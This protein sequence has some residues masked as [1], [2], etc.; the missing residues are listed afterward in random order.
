MNKTHGENRYIAGIDIGSVSVNAA[1]LNYQKEIIKTWYR[2]FH[3]NPVTVA[4]EVLEEVFLSFPSSEIAISATGAGGKLISKSLG[5]F[6][7]NEVIAQAKA[8]GYLYPEAKTIIEMGGQDS[9]FILIEKTAKG[10]NVKIT[11]FATNTIC[12]AGTGSFLDQQANRLGVSIEEEFSE[13]ALKSEKPPRIAGRCSVFAKSDMIHLQQTGTPDYDIVAGLC[14]AVAR[15]FKSSIARGKKFIKPVAFQGGVASNM[16]MVRAFKDILGLKDDE[17]LVHEHHCV[18][19]AIGAAL[20][21]LEENPDD[22]LFTDVKDLDKINDNANSSGA[23][24]LPPLMIEKSG[25]LHNPQY[26]YPLDEKTAGGKL[27]VYL[28]IDVGSISTNVVAIDEEGEVAAR[29]YLMTAG[30][31]IEAVRTGLGEIGDEIGSRVEVA[32][33]GT[34]GSG[35]YL[36]GDLVGADII[37]N[38]ITA[39]AKA[40]VFIDPEVDTIFEIGG[41]DS[42][43]VSLSGGVVSDF[44][45]NKVCAAGTGS[46]LEEQAEKLKVN[47][48]DEFSS[49]ALKSQ[50]PVKL[51]ERCTV[52]IESDIVHHQQQGVS[53][54]DIVSGLSYSIVHNYL[55]RV[56][57]NRKIGNKI[58]FQGGVA[59]N[60]GVI[61]AFEKVLDKKITVPPHHDVTGAIGAAL[62]A[63]ENKPSK[64]AFKG[65]DLSKKKFNVK[66][67]ECK[68]CTNLCEIRMITMEGEKPLF[69]GSRCEKYDIDRK[70]KASGFTNYFNLRKEYLLNPISAKK[71]ARNKKKKR[72]GIP[73]ILYFY[74][75]FPMWKSFFEEL[76]CEIVLSSETNKLIIEKGTENVAAET[77]FPVKVAHGHVLDLLEKEI[78]FLFMPSIISLFR[79]NKSFAENHTCPYVQAA[80]YIINSSLGLDGKN[81]E[82]LQPI[83]HLQGNN[84]QAGKA[85]REMGKKL[86]ASMSEY[87]QAYRVAMDV[88]KR[89][90]NS[91]KKLGENFLSSLSEDEK[92]IVIVSRPYNGF[93]SSI[94][95]GLPEKLSGLGIRTIPMDF[96]PLKDADISLY[97]PNMY[98]KA[99]QRILSAAQYIRNHP[100]LFAVYITNFGCGPDSFLTHF[101][102]DI[103]KG[104]PFLQIEIDEHSADTGAVTRCEAF[105]DSL[106]NYR[107]EIQSSARAKKLII[108]HFKNRAHTIFIPNMTDHSYA[109]KSAFNYNNVD[110]EVIAESDV[111]TVQLGREQTSGKECYPCILTTGDLFK[112]IKTSGLPPDRIAFFMPSAEGPCRFGQY[113]QLQRLLL[114][115]NGYEDVPIYSL[116]PEK[117]YSDNVFGKNFDLLAWKGIV[118]ID[119]LEKAARKARPYERKKGETDSVYNYCLKYICGIVKCNGDLARALKRCRKQFEAI[120]ISNGEKKPRI[121]VVGEIYI[122]SNCFSNHNL[123]RKV[124]DL[125]AEAW[126]APMSE[127]FLYANY[128]YKKRNVF[129]GKFKDLLKTIAKDKVQKMHEHKLYSAFDG[130]LEN[131][132]EPDTK[133][134]IEQSRK[135]VD[136]SFDGEAILSV[137][138]AIDYANRGLKGIINAIPFTCLPGTVVTAISRKLS[139]D[140]G[141]IPW[142]NISYDGIEDSGT[143][144]RLEA[145]I[146]QSKDFQ[147]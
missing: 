72:I 48:K 105:L 27:R 137:G 104:K 134:L 101:F 75:L 29:R 15:N 56:V 68:D 47:I 70:K 79:D 17:F 30:R 5:S 14:Y 62:L 38:E 52:F 8:A 97:H 93:D 35:R 122:R 115:D 43:Y 49:I 131:G 51:G 57:G 61:A 50:S 20:V 146:Y 118:A 16:G 114:D 69:Y 9:K 136:P 81:I 1:L 106:E 26:R 2:R 18:S 89:F 76:G 12:A 108:K 145:F 34:T 45:M 82:I 103:M 91:L 139:Q 36:T 113:R 120:A 40:A 11:D 130:F 78:D 96:L 19:G 32:A 53:G 77:C 110:A 132:C 99:G 22:C 135:Y 147:K 13:L 84:S 31:P 111:L 66:T 121:G 138:K 119:I 129:R 41:Q 90:Y 124:E 39:Q 74:E 71:S 107:Q 55:N 125:G 142:L 6:F 133:I 92:A 98:W 143:D 140:F 42:K 10:K 126:V 60:K 23:K 46:F 21:L 116:E 44:E 4:R 3:S 83:F 65:F 85:F 37:R 64:T 33:V 54:D 25:Y 58:F 87:L 117:S 88:Q 128:V 80:P 73:R 59:Y 109:I 127:W 95:L 123:I 63:C 144:N 86:G 67:F 24:N 141:N 102:S 94:N 28:G 7:V 112:T 100:N